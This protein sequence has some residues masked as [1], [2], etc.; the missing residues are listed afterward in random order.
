ML[1]LL[2]LFNAAEGP[3][4]HNLTAPTSSGMETRRNDA[5]KHNKAEKLYQ[6]SAGL[7]RPV[8]SNVL[9]C[10]ISNLTFKMKRVK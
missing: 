2:L 4:C 6:T 1:S 7:R 8:N 3:T 9:L 10:F 5:S